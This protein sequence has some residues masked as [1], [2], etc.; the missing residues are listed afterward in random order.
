MALEPSIVEVTI[1]AW[2]S[3][4]LFPEALPGIA[5]QLLV[6]GHDSPSLRDLAGLDLAPYDFRD[7]ADLLERIIPEMGIDEPSISRRL[8]IAAAILAYQCVANEISP[9]RT[10]HRFYSLAVREQYPKEPK[11]IMEFFILDDSWDTVPLTSGELDSEIT[12][13]ASNYLDQHMFRGWKPPQAVL[14]GIL[15]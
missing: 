13:K 4:I 10:T 6:D 2:R 14:D 5:T 8:E 12:V 11:E 7:A 9:R 3:G 1:C 15:T